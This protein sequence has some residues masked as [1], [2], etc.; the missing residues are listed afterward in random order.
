MD[1]VVVLTTAD[2]ILSEAARDGVIA[3]P[4]IDGVGSIACSDAVG[5][6]AGADGVVT[7]TSPSIQTLV[8]EA[9]AAAWGKGKLEEPC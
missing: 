4:C 9:E 5:A 3:T 8:G 6:K 7:I 1:G 2:E